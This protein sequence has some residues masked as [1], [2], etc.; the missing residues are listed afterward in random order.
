MRWCRKTDSGDCGQVLKSLL[1]R[2][3]AAMSSDGRA[4]RRVQVELLSGMSFI[5]EVMGV[6][7]EGGAQIAVFASSRR[8][9]VADIG[10]VTL[11]LS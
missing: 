1:S 7:G 9:A 3:K 5:D 8:V 6:E 11:E 4:E 10:V 2:A